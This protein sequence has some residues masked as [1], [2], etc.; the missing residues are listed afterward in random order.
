MKKRLIIICCFLGIFMQI[1]AQEKA[2]I[3]QNFPINISIL[4][5]STSLPNFWFLR[6]SYD[7]AIMIG[8]EYI[9]KQKAKS[10]FHLTGN[11]GYY[12]H[13]DWASTLF[14]LPEIGYRYHLKRWSFYARF[15]VGYSHSFATKP[16]YQ[17]E[18]GAFRET[19]DL[20]NPAAMVSLSLNTSF[21]LSDKALAPE[22]YVTLMSSGELPFNNYTGV[23]QF[24]GVGYK[25]YPFK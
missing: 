22:I 6:Y 18:E 24:A 1:N 11:I 19:N 15:G 13:E 14:I 21:K 7:P 12:Y 4:D 10:D 5:E 16:I 25:F 8:T 9:L 3:K 23:H 20:G 17:F 2:T